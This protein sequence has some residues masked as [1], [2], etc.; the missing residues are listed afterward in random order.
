MKNE[1]NAPPNSSPNIGNLRPIDFLFPN[2]QD[3]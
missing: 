2:L 3:N 1:P